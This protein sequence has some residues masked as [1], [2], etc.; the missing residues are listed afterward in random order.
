MVVLTTGLL[1]KMRY[2]GNTV[3]IGIR[4]HAAGIEPG[5]DI[6]E[7]NQETNRRIGQQVNPVQVKVSFLKNLVEKPYEAQAQVKFQQ[8]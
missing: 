4:G 3:K 6:D 7:W 5:I 8:V 2:G 1:I